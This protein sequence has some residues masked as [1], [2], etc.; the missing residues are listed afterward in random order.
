MSV[1]SNIST[2]FVK[3]WFS[4]LQNTYIGKKSELYVTKFLIQTMLSWLH[5]KSESQSKNSKI[6]ETLF[7]KKK[8]SYKQINS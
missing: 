6:R 8:K 4:H 1:V 5:K 2:T 3:I 7:K